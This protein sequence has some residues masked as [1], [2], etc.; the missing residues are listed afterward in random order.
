[1][2]VE[3]LNRLH[4]KLVALKER[5]KEATQGVVVGY[6]QTYAVYVHE[7]L[8]ASHAEGKQAKY[9]EQPAREMQAELGGIVSTV[10]A[11]TGSVEKGLLAAGLRLQRESQKL[12]PIDTGALKASAFTALEDE[13]EAV[14]QHAYITS[15]AIRAS[16][17][18]KRA[19]K[20]AKARAKRK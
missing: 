1:M 15:Q 18:D 4:A 19:K 16:A 10:A 5:G 7:N 3:N 17:I 14:S 6:T 9:L 11:K 13:V 12:V 20:A 2:R 8:N